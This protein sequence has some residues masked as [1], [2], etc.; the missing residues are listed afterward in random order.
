VR[1]H[2]GFRDLLLGPG[3]LVAVVASLGAATVLVVAGLGWELIQIRTL[4]L[5]EATHP[6]VRVIAA[7]DVQVAAPPAQPAEHASG[8]EPADPA[9]PTPSGTEPAVFS[10]EPPAHDDGDTAPAHDE[11]AEAT[12][13]PAPPAAEAT[14][15]PA[16][17]VAVESS[18]T[19]AALA[20]RRRRDPGPRGAP[21]AT[22]DIPIV[23]YH[24]VGPL[25]PNADIF[26][27]DLTV[28]PS[29]FEDELQ[30][31]AEQGVE[32][33]SLDDLMEHYAGGP[34]LPKRSVILTFDD[35]YDDAYDF[36]FPL[37][38][39]YGM[40]GTFFI[41]TEFVGR[42][43]Y[44]TWEQ[45][46]EMD[47]AGMSIEAHSAT[48]ADLSVVGPAELRRQLVEPKR[49]LEEQLGHPVRFLAYPSGKYNAGTVAATK[50]A[51]YLAAVT[52]V[53]GTSHPA[54]APFE[55]TRVRARGADTS[56]ALV[57]RMTPAS[58][59]R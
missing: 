26:R 59:R 23:M 8:A 43:G 1:R 33:V 44:L 36:A 41:V 21:R 15:I 34:E 28:V 53:H 46:K 54:S 6:P 45:I 39:Q 2:L 9:D 57:A 40:T 32:T 25:P 38:Q 10:S 35:G 31:F 24:H 52:V 5:T 47:A 7:S 51:G 49:A 14:P 29:L 55:V 58:W 13:R 12:P 22:A 30:R 50:A 27:K 37:L 42:P 18:P 16:P 3:L 48:H 4:V 11:V 19:P 17:A 56:A 20:A